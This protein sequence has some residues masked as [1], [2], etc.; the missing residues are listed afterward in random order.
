MATHRLRAE[1]E[2]AA[3]GSVPP[4]QQAAQARLLDL[5][6][7]HGGRVTDL[8]YAM[9]ISKQ[10]LGQLVTQLAGL[11]YVDLSPDPADK[12]A[13]LIYRTPLGDRVQRAM[14]SIIAEVE[15]RWRDE[16]GAERYAMFRDVLRELVN[17]SGR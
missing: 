11:G 5:I 14:R 1:A 15:Q 8:S 7:P 13:K 12:R 17:R 16:I 9:R 10:G 6:P 2:T 4:L 3:L